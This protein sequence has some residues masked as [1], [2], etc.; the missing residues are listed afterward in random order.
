MTHL[1]QPPRKHIRRPAP[2]IAALN[3]RY[4]ETVRSRM[5]CSA[6]TAGGWHGRTVCVFLRHESDHVF[7]IAED[8]LFG[9]ADFVTLENATFHVDEP[10]RLEAC[11][12]EGLLPNGRNVHA[13][14]IGRLIHAAMDSHRTVPDDWSSIVY[15]PHRMSTFQVAATGQSIHHADQV[16]F[17]PIPL[18]VRCP[19]PSAGPQPEGAS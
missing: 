10:G 9:M 13:F 5:M 2:D 8:R 7:A 16:M 1:L 17:T 12:G 3:Q 15:N 18:L 19:L 4:L 6:E 11:Q 14:V